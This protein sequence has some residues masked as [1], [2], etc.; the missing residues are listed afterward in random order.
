MQE[1][2]RTGENIRL[3]ARVKAGQHPGFY[4]VV[5]A[6]IPGS[7]PK[8]GERTLKRRSRGATWIR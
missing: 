5:T 6:T 7:D 2:L 4:E 1:R 3:H 8:L